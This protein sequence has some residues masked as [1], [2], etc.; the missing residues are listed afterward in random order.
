MHIQSAIEELKERAKT[1]ALRL[2]SGASETSL[3]EVERIYSKTL[4][5]DFK[6]LYRFS[7]GFDTDEDIFNMIR[8]EEIIENKMKYNNQLY[9]AE[10][11]TYCD[12]WELDISIQNP[13]DYQITNLTR[14]NTTITLTRSLAEFIHRFLQG[15]VF[16]A[17][18]LYDWHEETMRG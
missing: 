15:G 17:A 7:D 3:K 11:M 1:G 6:M 10:Y 13:N 16:D 8:I 18:G 14:L 12:S 4:P 5:E 2:H 9:I